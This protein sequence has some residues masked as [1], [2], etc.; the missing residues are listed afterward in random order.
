MSSIFNLLGELESDGGQIKPIARSK[1]SH[2]IKLNSLK[3]M[4]GAKPKGLSIRSNSDMNL[5][6]IHSAKKSMHDKEQDCLKLKVTQIDSNGRP[7]SPGKEFVKMITQS[8][9]VKGCAL[10]EDTTINKCTKKQL[11][12]G[13]FKKPLLP[14]KNINRLPKPEKLVHWHDSQHDFDYGYIETAEKEFRDLLSKGKENIKPCEENVFVSETL[15]MPDISKFTLDKTLDE[16]HKKLLFPNLV[17]P[18][19]S[20][21]SDDENL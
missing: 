14:K 18:E 20:D 10:K 16:E 3:T 4:G 5:S 7:I 8:P 2:E 17:T 12:D 6:S 15:V 1:T 11:N 21:I 13:V 9:K 19:V